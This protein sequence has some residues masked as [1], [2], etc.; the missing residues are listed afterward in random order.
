V[1]TFGVQSGDDSIAGPF[2]DTDGDGRIN[3]LEYATQ[4]SVSVNDPNPLSLTQS[5]SPTLTFHRYVAASDA[6]FSIEGSS[7][8]L[9]WQTLAQATGMGVWSSAQGFTV[10]ETSDGTVSASDNTAAS[11]YFYRLRVDVP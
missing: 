7:D 6:T 1:R 10:T 8:L 2:V 5:P 9:S 11:R 3:A 4:S